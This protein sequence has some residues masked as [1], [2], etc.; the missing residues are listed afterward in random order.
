[1]AQISKNIFKFQQKLYFYTLIIK[2]KLFQ[3]FDNQ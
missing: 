2:T 3:I 1:M